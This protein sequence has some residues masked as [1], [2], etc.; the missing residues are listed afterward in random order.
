[1]LRKSPDSY[2]WAG[3]FKNT[4]FSGSSLKVKKLNKL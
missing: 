4:D 1:M 2:A 3:I